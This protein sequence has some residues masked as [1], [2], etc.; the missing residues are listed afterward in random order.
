[1]SFATL[2]PPLRS[3][4]A[5]EAS[6]KTAALIG[7]LFLTA[8]AAFIGA[9]T[10]NSGVLQ[11]PDFLRTASGQTGALATSALLL[12][13]QFG[14]VGIAV[15]L[16]PLL[17]PH[18]PSLALAHVGFRTAELAAS[19]FYLAIPLTT[20]HL[21][22]GLRDGTVDTAV[23][24]SLAALLQAQYSV[25]ILMIY[26]VTTAAGMCMAILLFRSRLIPRWLAVLGLASYPALLAGCILN[27]FGVID[28]TQ[29][30]GLIA[31][32]PGGLFELILPIWLLTKG[33]C[34]PP[35][36]DHPAER[37]SMVPSTERVGPR[38]VGFN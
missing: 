34:T 31:L 27:L 4:A 23:S 19:L 6:K 2:P 33:F 25:T 14:V 37:T 29:G 26:L 10:L 16:Y 28:V 15:L 1:M 11:Q 13:G 3:R 24:T 8:T 35:L 12:F 9:D 17:K 36:D 5:A 32:V 38:Q 18:C 20:I 30:I 7:L 21:A 22:T